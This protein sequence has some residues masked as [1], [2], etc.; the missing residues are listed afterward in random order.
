[1]LTKPQTKVTS[2][3]T[4]KATLVTVNHSQWSAHKRDKEI[5][6]EVNTK[7]GAKS[8]AGNYNK[9]L[10]EKQ[11][12][13]KLTNIRSRVRHLIETYTKP[14]LT[15][16][17]RI[18]PNMLYQQFCNEFRVLKREHEQEADAFA[19]DF[20]NLIEERKADLNGMFK[21]SDYPSPAE[22]RSKFSLE[23]K[24]CPIAE[25]EGFSDDFR[26]QLD[27]ET[28]ADIKAE[29]DK[30]NAHL[31]DN[32]RKDSVEKILDVVGHM[33]TALRQYDTGDINRFNAS[34]VENI[35]ELVSVLPAF[36]L[37]DD[38]KFDALVKRIESDLCVEDAKTLREND[39]V[40]EDV[41]KRAEQIVKDVEKFFG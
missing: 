26:A 41:Q 14:W 35:R 1:M 16:G 33:A 32:V 20:A 8:D 13:E 22:I 30:T 11:R 29:L 10:I 7:H 21:A 4:S 27:D 19:A 38:P 12:M 24:I 17:P 5:T 37:T 18:L 23:M 40:R 28:L 3:L 34:L 2:P 6:D 25:A 9:R 15:K 39:D 36:N 31:L